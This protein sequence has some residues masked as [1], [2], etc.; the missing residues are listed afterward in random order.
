MFIVHDF[1]LKVYLVITNRINQFKT[2]LTVYTTVAAIIYSLVC[3]I[4]SSIQ[5]SEG[6]TDKA[7]EG[8]LIVQVTEAALILVVNAGIV[9]TVLRSLWLR[10]SWQNSSAKAMF[11]KIL[12]IGLMFEITAAL[13][14]LLLFRQKTWKDRIPRRYD[15]VFFLYILFGEIA[16]QGILLYGILSYTNQLRVRHLR[17]SLS[18]NLT[19]STESPALTDQQR[20]SLDTTN[21]IVE[22]SRDTV[23]RIESFSCMNTTEETRQ[24]ISPRHNRNVNLRRT[25]DLMGSGEVTT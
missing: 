14:I 16:C 3:F 17:G 25:I 23:A 24:L 8:F 20:T 19:L 4:F 13:R 2:C 1:L 15:F 21:T 6:Y 18:G 9:V 11:I 7:A 22:P 10:V 12:L 5:C